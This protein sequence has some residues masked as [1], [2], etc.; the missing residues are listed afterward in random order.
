MFNGEKPC[1]SIDWALV[2]E[3]EMEYAIVEADWLYYYDP[4]FFSLA[5]SFWLIH[6]GLILT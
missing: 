5:S 3:T 4:K 6:P 2:A 1:D